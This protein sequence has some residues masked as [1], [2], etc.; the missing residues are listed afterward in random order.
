[1][2]YIGTMRPAMC[3]YNRPFVILL[4]IRISGGQRVLNLTLTFAIEPT[5][6]DQS[7][8]HQKYKE[9]QP[10]KV[11]TNNCISGGNFGGVL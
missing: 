9:F 5:L 6:P 4:V 7:L 3:D 10:T 1:M 11:H 2:Y 8:F